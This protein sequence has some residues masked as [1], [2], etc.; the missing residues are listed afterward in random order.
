MLRVSR[1]RSRIGGYFR[2]SVSSTTTKAIST[3]TPI[4][5]T[6]PVSIANPREQLFHHLKISSFSET[7]IVSAHDI[8]S[9][10]VNKGSDS[11]SNETN[12]D[13]EVVLS[14]AKSF[15]LMDPSNKTVLDQNEFR[16]RL[17]IVGE[18]LDKRVWPVALSFGAT[19]LSI[20]III[21][22]LPLLVKEINLPS[23]VFGLA[24]SAFGLAKLIGNPP[25]AQW[26]EKYGR[27]PV[28]VGG[29]VVCAAGLGCIGFSLIPEL[30]APW[31]IACRFVTG[32]GVAAFT[33]G[34]F[35]YMNDI[36]TALNRTRTM[37]PLMSSFQAG[38]A[39]GPAIG[40]IAVEALG[41]MGSYVMVG[42]SIAGLAGLNA[43]FLTESKAVLPPPPPSSSSTTIKKEEKEDFSSSY[44]SFG[45]AFIEW[46]RLMK[47]R[48]I[49]DTVILNGFYWL[50]LA[51]VQLTL[52][53]LFMVAEPLS[54]SPAQIGS[55][56]AAISIVSVVTSQPTAYFA[57]KYGKV[58][59]IVI[60][61]GALA[62]SFALIPQTESFQQLLFAL[63]PLA[64]G[65]T[66]L[67]S[68]PTAHLGDLTST[69]DRAQALALLR[70]AGDVGL[71]CGAISSGALAEIVGMSNTMI[72][73]SGLLSAATIWYFTRKSI[74]QKRNAGTM[75]P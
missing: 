39:V 43:L 25:S 58:P 70:T 57:D 1:L 31:L 51:G 59:S 47:D 8:L 4:T 53:P 45:L 71:L 28:M 52:L 36:S 66:L 74:T 64:L 22:I 19:G 42:G 10:H 30:G 16:D 11:N 37:A 29:M 48:A 73:N 15:E 21:P 72:G 20:G 38:T 65:S 67:S 2:T 54:L 32:F 33:S 24:V 55:S 13:S 18:K 14:L 41:I 62:T 9:K 27:K 34:A 50:S 12:K 3:T 44:S 69:E 7:E 75:K 60:G 5:S 26:V 23:S 68:V 40:G 35:M 6:V 46:K 56:F 49:R 63:T 61:A 17:R